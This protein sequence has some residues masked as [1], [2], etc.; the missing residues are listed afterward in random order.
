MGY[1]HL[2]PIQQHNQLVLIKILRLLMADLGL[3]ASIEL[4]DTLSLKEI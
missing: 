2:F 3:A 1:K 4:S